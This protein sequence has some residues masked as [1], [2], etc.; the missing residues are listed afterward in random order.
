MS[1]KAERHEPLHLQ[2]SGHYKKK[3][4]DGEIAPGARL[5]SVRDIATEWEVGQETAARAIQQLKTAGLVRTGP[6][7]TFALGRREKYGPQQRIRAV[8]FPPSERVEILAAEVIRAPEYV[9]PIL[10]LIG[11]QP[12][13]ARRE[14]IT[15]EDSN[16]PFMLS[17]TWCARRYTEQVPE[18]LALFPL[19][20]AG[21][22]AKLIASRTGREITWGVS[23]REARHI[24][25]DG[26]EGPLLRLPR[27][28]HVLAETYVWA[29]GDDIVE[30][31]EY[32][33]PENRVIES[34]MEP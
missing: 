7:G 27:D 5:P 8:T 34:D 9:V 23:A 15:Y 6:D 19:P 13:V 24:Q 20:D 21:G 3:M 11:S 1:P 30:Y 33:L 4:L 32:I 16:V 31:G 2:I 28:G 14:W 17:V 18:L 26:R 29:C 25:D 12:L 10:G 22:A